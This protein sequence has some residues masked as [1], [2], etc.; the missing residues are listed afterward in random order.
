[1]IC[2][3]LVKFLA[4]FF[5]FM[6]AGCTIPFKTIDLT[7]PYNYNELANEHRFIPI[8]EGASYSGKEP[9]EKFLLWLIRTKKVK[10][11]ISLK[12]N[13]SKKSENFIR[14]NGVKLITF[15]WTARRVPPKHEIEKISDL[16]QDG[17]HQPIY[18]FCRSGVDRTGFFRAYYRFFYQGWTE[19]DALREFYGM[20][21]IPNVLDEYLKKI[22]VK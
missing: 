19:E 21:H 8:E 11:F 9:D 17:R 7:K 3:V 2:R 4:M 22:F 10:T 14:K 15:R 1:M 18:L 6:V 20:W 5:G 16:M 13:I 12:G